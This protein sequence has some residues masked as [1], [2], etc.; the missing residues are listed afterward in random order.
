MQRDKPL[1]AQSRLE[2][3]PTRHKQQFHIVGTDDPQLGKGWVVRRLPDEK[4]DVWVPAVGEAGKTYFRAVGG[5]D[6]WHFM[7][8]TKPGIPDVEF[9]LPMSAA[10]QPTTRP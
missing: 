7:A 8:D 3:R 2:S 4:L 5:L 1:H 10:T 9:P 6:E